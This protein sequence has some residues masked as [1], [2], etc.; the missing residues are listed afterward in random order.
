MATS[1]TSQGLVAAADRVILSSRPFLEFV[2]LF[3][4]NLEP[5]A[6]A[7]YSAIAVNVLSASSEDFGASAGYTHPTNSIKPATCTLTS[8]RKSTFT[9]S[10]V[11]ALTNELAPCWAAMPGKAA[12]GVASYVVQQIMAL[13]TYGNATDQITQTF[14][15]GL[16]DFT[17]LAAATMAKGIDPTQCALILEPT[18]Y[19]KLIAALPAYVLGDDEAIRT[20]MVGKFLGFKAVVPSP[21]CSKASAADVNNGVGFIVPEGA[22]AVANRVVVPV[23]AG[24]NLVEFGTVTDEA[25]GWSFGL[26]SV[27]DA[28][29]GTLSVSVDTLFGAVLSKQS[30]NGAPG[31]YQIKTA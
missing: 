3:S 1:V 16:A 12:E 7:R 29:Q 23:Q 21:N 10:D 18:T 11:D 24:G 25:T 15:S 9:I 19:S 27:V 30:S 26:R 13:L 2:K 14:S 22:I 4:T 31:Y 28:D 6:G 20:G 8:H 17:A 5:V